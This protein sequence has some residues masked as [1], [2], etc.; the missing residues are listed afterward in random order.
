MQNNKKLVGEIVEAIK[1]EL[2]PRF[3]EIGKKFETIDR[4]FEA[5]DQRFDAMDQRFDGMDKKMDEG[6]RQQGVLLEAMQDDINTLVDGQEILHGRIDRVQGT[7]SRIESKVEDI[8]VR[9]TAV[10]VG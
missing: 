3:G 4:R 5:I 9:L 10:E 1:V 2:E 6:F 7:A 8:D